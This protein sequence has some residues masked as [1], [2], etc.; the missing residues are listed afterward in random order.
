MIESTVK[1]DRPVR[2]GIFSTVAQAEQAVNGLLNAG[3]SRE[4]VSIVTS[5]HYKEA[6]LPRV[7]HEDPAGTHTPATTLAGSLI[8]ATLG[9]LVVVAAAAATGGAALLVS[10]GIAAWA[11]GV[12]GGL[13]GAMMSRGVEPE[14]ANYYNQAVLDGKILVAAEDE[15]PRQATQL[16][17]AE[18]VFSALGAEP[19]PLPEG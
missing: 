17:A 8:G 12:A 11:G 16:A 13:I 14:I 7:H 4:Q 3:F 18:A 10:G 15:G 1:T 2:V 19:L 5:D 9:G 6:L